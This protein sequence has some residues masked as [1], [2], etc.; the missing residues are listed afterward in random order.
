MFVDGL[1]LLA[2]VILFGCDCCCFI[3]WL[4]V[5]GRHCLCIGCITVVVVVVVVNQVTDQ[6]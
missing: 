1:W 6:G 4:L 2:V 5:V 3:C